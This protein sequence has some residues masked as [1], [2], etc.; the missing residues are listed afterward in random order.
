[1]MPAPFALGLGEDSE[2][3]APQLT[4]AQAMGECEWPVTT[5]YRSLSSLIWTSYPLRPSNVDLKIPI[6]S[7]TNTGLREV[8]QHSQCHL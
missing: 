3:E 2:H 6:L 1:M 8:K 7:T 5:V 4:T